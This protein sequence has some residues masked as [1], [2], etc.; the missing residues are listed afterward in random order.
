MALSVNERVANLRA[1]RRV[2][3]EDTA[4]DRAAYAAARFAA[5]PAEYHSPSDLAKSL[6]PEDG[7]TRIITRAGT[8]PATTTTTGWA[9]DV[10]LPATGPFLES[11]GPLSAAAQLIAAGQQITLR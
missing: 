11:L 1:R 10:A 6:W 3:G 7:A 9:S 2:A 5:N 8:S 4:F